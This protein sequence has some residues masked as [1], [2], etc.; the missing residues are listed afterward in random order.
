M[1]SHLD[2]ER[3]AAAIV[4]ISTKPFA[5]LTTIAIVSVLLVA[6]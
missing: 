6:F 5:I 2:K 1:Y 3:F 4:L